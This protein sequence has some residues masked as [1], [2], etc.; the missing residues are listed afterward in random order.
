MDYNNL[1]WEQIKKQAEETPPIG[2]TI[3]F[4]IDEYKIHIDG[5]GDKNIL[6]LSD[7]EAECIISTTKKTLAKLNDNKLN[8][9]TALMTKKIKVRGN[10]ALLLKL[11][12]LL[13]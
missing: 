12:D 8:L 5:T 11:Q 7:E 6:T 2:G 13:P 10:M 9:I 3:K 4:E 1:L